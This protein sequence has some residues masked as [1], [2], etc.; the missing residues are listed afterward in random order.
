MRAADIR[1]FVG[2]ARG[3]GS[4]L[5]EEIAPRHVGPVVVSG[6]LAEQLAKELGAGASPGAV[7]LRAGAVPANAEVLVH[8]IAGDPSADDESLVRQV[9]ANNGE[10]VIVE[11]WPQA[12]WTR[13]FVLSPFVVECRAGEGFPI[14][15]IADRIV[16]ATE[17]AAAL[18]ARVPTIA[19]ATRASLVKQ[20]VIRSALIGLAG[21]RLGMSRP[22]LVREQVRMVSRLRAVSS[23]SAVSDEL[24]MLAGGAVSVLVSG[25]ALRG[26]ARAARAVLPAPLAHAAIAA[27]GTWAFA[28]AYEVLESRLP[29]A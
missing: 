7:T 27:G 25:F 28:K 2:E 17:H 26:L 21:S 16:E 24:P 8:V 29:S 19:E 5:R 1:A 3:L 13:P 15:E 9:V 4:A 20:A 12:D 6:V 23:G 22:L 18:A 14:R 10:V 11:L